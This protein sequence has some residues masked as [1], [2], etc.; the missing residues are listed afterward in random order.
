MCELCK[1]RVAAPATDA[2][3]VHSAELT[4]SLFLLQGPPPSAAQAPRTSMVNGS[5]A[6]HDPRV[7]ATAFSLDGLTLRAG[8]AARRAP[9]RLHA[10][11]SPSMAAPPKN[12]RR[13]SCSTQLAPIYFG[14]V[15]HAKDP[16]AVR[17]TVAESRQHRNDD[18]VTVIRHLHDHRRAFFFSVNP[19]GVQADGVTRREGRRA[20]A[21][22]GPHM[23]TSAC[24]PSGSR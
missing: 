9:H 23:A 3:A 4:L 15:A 13:S 17:A 16:S 12:G 2:P 20:P 1:G 7:T 22:R 18:R 11:I 8:L 10:S 5:P 21:F 6:L 19:L 14:I 24:T